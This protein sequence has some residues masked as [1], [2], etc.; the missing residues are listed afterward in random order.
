MT[1]LLKEFA[2]GRFGAD[3]ILCLDADEFIDAESPPD[4]RRALSLL[5]GP[6]AIEW[7]TY[8]PRVEDDGREINPVLRILHHLASEVYQYC[9]VIVPGS[10]G[11]RAETHL[12]QGNHAV[13]AG[14]TALAMTAIHGAT[15]AHFPVRNPEQYA[16]K[17]A[18]RALQY[19]AMYEK[20]AGWGWELTRYWQMMK[21]D[22]QRVIDTYH[23][24]AIE[25]CVPPGMAREENPLVQSPVSYR[26]GPLTASARE[27]ASGLLVRRLLGYAEGLALS[28]AGL[29]EALRPDRQDLAS[30]YAALWADH[31]SVL[32]RCAVLQKD[33][34]RLVSRRMGH[35]LPV[36]RALWRRARSIARRLHGA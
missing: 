33:Y 9:K 4:F 16:W 11:A 12:G 3:W 31:E 1:R 18:L 7:R 30:S 24:G 29:H 22:P 28:Y 26:G 20:K 27:N 13:F 10:I 6:V 2:V 19:A 35:L 36:F 17:V 34:E 5:D 25:Y 32:S 15:L 8:V 21:E 23:E 14:E